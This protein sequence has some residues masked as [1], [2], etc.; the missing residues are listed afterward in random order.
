MSTATGTQASASGGAPLASVLLKPDDD[1][2]RLAYAKWCD[3]QL[4]TPSTTARGVFIRN[5]IARL[6]RRNTGTLPELRKLA[7]EANNARAEHGDAWDQPLRSLA[8]SVEYD[9]GFVELVRMSAS[10]FRDKAVAIRKLA[11]VRHLDLTGVVEA[12]PGFLA[13]EVLAGVR[14]LSMD[15]CGLTDREIADLAGSPHVGELRWLSIGDNLLTVKSGEAMASSKNLGKLVYA[16]FLGNPYDPM[17]RYSHDG[18]IVGS[19]WLPIEGKRL[20]A[21]HRGPIAWLHW[22]G[23][24]SA[25]LIPDRFR[26]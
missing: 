11:P 8:S 7:A 24:T 25:E 3:A 2:P 23:H 17:N 4:L 21:K 22:V 10:A 16:G 20:E 19:I 9:R 18:E 13:S 15:R 6:N 5:Q 12:G 14:S 26:V 1:D